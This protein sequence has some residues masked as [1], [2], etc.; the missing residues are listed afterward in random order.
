MLTAYVNKFR[1]A[2]IDLPCLYPYFQPDENETYKI[3]KIEEIV[4]L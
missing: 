2:G 3:S 4:Q 1:Q